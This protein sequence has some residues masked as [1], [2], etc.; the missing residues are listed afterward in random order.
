[1]AVICPLGNQFLAILFDA[2]S[3]L[4]CLKNL[5]GFRDFFN[6]SVS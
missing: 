5:N 6:E 2:Q 1:M 3:H 4:N